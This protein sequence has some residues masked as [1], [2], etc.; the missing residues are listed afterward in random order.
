MSESPRRSPKQPLKAVNAAP[1]KPA[2]ERPKKE[3]KPLYVPP[4]PKER[5]IVKTS[6]PN[7]K[8]GDKNIDT[9]NVSKIEETPTKAPAKA[10]QAE[11]VEEL[12][13]HLSQREKLHLEDVERHKAH[14]EQG[15]F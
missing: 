5:K 2:V 11:H 8:N 6:T 10:R 4:P 14:S 1:P 9:P 12:R 7:V 13:S 3:R 15:G